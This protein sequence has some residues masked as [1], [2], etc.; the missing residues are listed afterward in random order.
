MSTFAGSNSNFTPSTSVD[1]YVL[2]ATNTTGAVGIVESI[3]WGGQLNT[4]TSYRTT[5][6]RPATNASST[7]TSVTPQAGNPAQ[8]PVCRLGTFAT[9]A[10]LS[11]EPAGLFTESWNA[12]GG[13]GYVT[14][15]INGAWI[16]VG[17]TTAGQGQIAC[18]NRA[19]TDASGSTYGISW[20]E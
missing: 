16:V 8:T 5:W 13:L 11:A 12:F 7:F 3:G 4:A 20:R 15:P 10:S 17:T 14:F 6:A 18:R 19:G 1:N 2:D 9:S